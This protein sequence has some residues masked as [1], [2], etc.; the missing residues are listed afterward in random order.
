LLTLR[1]AKESLQFGVMLKDA[2]AF[3][4]QWH[5]GKMIFIDT[6]S[7]EKYDET[8]PWV[9]Y[10]QFCEHFLGP[11]LLMHY[12]KLP[13]TEMLLA[14]PDGMPLRATAGLL[15]RRTRFSLPVYLHIHLHSKYSSKPTAAAK[16]SWQFSKKKMLNLL[17]SLGQLVNRLRLPDGQSAWSAYYD[18]ASQRKDYLEKKKSIVSEWL[19][20][21]FDVQTA[22]DLGANDSAF[23]RL[24][25]AK[26]IFTIAADADAFCIE[27]LYQ[28]IVHTKDSNLQPLIID[29]SHPTPAIGLNNQERAAFTDRAKAGLVLALAVIHHLAIGKNIP[30]DKI[31]FFFA[32]ISRKWLIVEFIPKSDDKIMQ[33][34]S[35]KKDI[36][37]N[38]SMEVFENVFRRYFDIR[39][40]KEIGDSGRTIY[41]MK[42]HDA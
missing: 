40:K 36:Y 28:S 42:K 39:E 16:K 23:S 5:K 34:L 3:N 35:S 26:N 41:L 38:Y 11:L 8:R 22:M 20:Q 6:L 27:R 30:L 15:P 37:D 12:R 21:F 25:S 1:I 31:A 24:L 4:V 33:M 29:L 7:F 19:P 18:E 32:G 13:L 17:Q 14:W 10:R 2:S 9:A